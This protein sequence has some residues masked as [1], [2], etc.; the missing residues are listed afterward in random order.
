MAEEK[1]KEMF[2]DTLEEWIAAHK[3]SSSTIEYELE[4]ALDNNSNDNKQALLDFV[5]SL[6][7]L[8]AECQGEIKEAKYWIKSMEQE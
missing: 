7:N 5:D 1:Q 4:Q 3:H 8:I 2:F 6:D